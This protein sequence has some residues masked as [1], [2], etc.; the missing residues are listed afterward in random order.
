MS[1]WR[2]EFAFSPSAVAMMLVQ[3]QQTS[4]SRIETHTLKIADMCQIMY[5]TLMTLYTFG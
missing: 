3:L 1:S 5:S 4:N 2:M